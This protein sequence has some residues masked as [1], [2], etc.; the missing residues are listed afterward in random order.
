M[1]LL[2]LLRGSRVHANNSLLSFISADEEI[3]NVSRGIPRRKYSAGE[4]IQRRARGYQGLFKSKY[5][6]QVVST[7][8]GQEISRLAIE[9]DATRRSSRDSL[10]NAPRVRSLI[11]RFSA[12]KKYI[13]SSVSFVR[14]RSCSSTDSLTIFESR[15]TLWLKRECR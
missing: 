13:Y 12:Y 4:S 14:L 3:N 2:R 5:H 1:R 11:L 10:C 7:T 6:E 15:C 9:R 8:A